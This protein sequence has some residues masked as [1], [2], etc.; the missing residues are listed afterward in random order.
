MN[1]K[2]RIV[3]GSH[4]GTDIS[5]YYHASSPPVRGY[6]T[7]GDRV[8]N[9]SFDG[10]L[11][12]IKEWI[13]VTTGPAVR[14]PWVTGTSYSVGDQVTSSGNVYLCAI[15]G[16]AG[17]IAPTGTSIFPSV[18]SGGYLYDGAGSTGA[19][20][21]IYTG[22][23]A[24]AAW[25]SAADDLTFSIDVKG[26]GAKGD[27]ATDDTA[28]IQAAIN[29]A[30]TIKS[31]PASSGPGGFVN[32]A[33]VIFP[34][35]SYLVSNAS[36]IITLP[37][38]CPITLEGNNAT[39]LGSSASYNIIN[40]T[41][42]Y[43]HE[44]HNMQ[45]VGGAVQVNV[46]AGAAD[47]FSPINQTLF[48]GCRF[49]GAT[50]SSVTNPSSA[51]GV[52]VY[53]FENCSFGIEN[54]I[55]TTTFLN[56]RGCRRL[57]LS[58]C[59]FV[60]SGTLLT[61]GI[62]ASGATL[63]VNIDSCE[64]NPAS[65]SP[66]W[67]NITNCMLRCVNSK[68]EYGSGM[69][70]LKFYTATSGG[71]YWYF[72]IGEVSFVDCQI[73]STTASTTGILQFY[74]LPAV[75]YFNRNVLLDT[76]GI[77]G[78]GKVFYFDGGISEF[79]SK[80]INDMQQFMSRWDIDPQM[81]QVAGDVDIIADLVI[82]QGNTPRGTSVPDSS[83]Y[84]MSFSG[85]S[86]LGFYA[87]GSRG[88]GGGITSNTSIT[89]PWSRSV[90]QL[91]I[92]GSGGYDG[93][94]YYGALMQAITTPGTYTAVFFVENLSDAVI[95]QFQVTAGAR[96]T[97]FSLGRGQHLLSVPFHIKTIPTLWAQST[98]YVVGNVAVVSAVG[99]A[100]NMGIP[101][102]CVQSGT[103]SPSGTGPQS[104]TGTGA[105][106][107]DGSVLWAGFDNTGVGFSS[108]T[109]PANSTINLGDI[110]VYSGLVDIKDINSV[111]KGNALP[112]AGL[113]NVGDIIENEAPASAGH[114]GWVCTSVGFASKE[115]WTL[116]HTYNVGD[117]VTNGSLV[118]I[119]VYSPGIAETGTGPTGY[120][121]YPGTNGAMTF[122][123]TYKWAWYAG[124][125][126]P[127]TFKTYG[128]IS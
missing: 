54:G 61:D 118:Y 56:M 81:W 94:E 22:A 38:N 26:F 70:V 47:D 42:S 64:F 66:N 72:P 53:T 112:V 63:Q 45:F 89:G 44:F 7:K 115:A 49:T 90:S 106:I 8:L 57:N 18:F 120:P 33:K 128:L 103:S 84:L 127:P 3:K 2:V 96:K 95:N 13:C 85:G 17:A 15:A 101:M 82:A 71:W 80:R 9:D 78:G 50:T 37:N 43:G 25:A 11:H 27:G 46:Q 48:R 39:L 93:L 102:I 109:L 60:S 98:S 5:S 10:N 97:E 65:G 121:F 19:A 52:G 105:P 31:T 83:R 29:F 23:A 34:K 107:L 126:T 58:K 30:A 55:T 14:G 124:N 1:G 92:G 110:R 59:S 68:F 88:N 24:T 35:G 75:L 73:V 117:V 21:Q 114:M 40:I 79:A 20:W 77:I 32:T 91:V 113:W 119:C 86:S 74:G 4:E 67:L 36:T 16:T 111:T 108:Y 62:T 116:G 99:P 6:W 87:I 12:P 122:G 51:D 41:G 123:S 28:A 125:T 104:D 69:S 100:G 76:V